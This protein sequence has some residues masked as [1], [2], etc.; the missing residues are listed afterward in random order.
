MS[1]KRPAYQPDA[2]TFRVERDTRSRYLRG[3]NEIALTP[4]GA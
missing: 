2:C 3:D 1:S 4:I